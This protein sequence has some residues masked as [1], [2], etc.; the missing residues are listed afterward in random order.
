MSGQEKF[1]VVSAGKT[2]RAK[3]PAEV[4]QEAAKAFSIPVAQARRLMV[5][6]WVIKDQLSSKQVIE[7]RARLQKVGL[8]V[9]VFP[10][11]QYDNRALVAKLEFAQKRRARS[12][13]QETAAAVHGAADNMGRVEKERVAK[14]AKATK[15]AKAEKVA[16]DTAAKTARPEPTTPAPSGAAP[17]PN[18]NGRA[19]AQ[20]EALFAGES[21]SLPGAAANRVRLLLGAIAAAVVPGLFVLLA[22]ICVYSVI[23]TLWGLVQSVTAGDL[24]LFTIAGGLL[25]LSLIAFVAAI[26]L[27]PLVVA[28]RFDIGAERDHVPLPRRDAQGLYLLLEVLAER[29]GLPS[30]SAISVTAG[31]EI[32][33]GPVDFAA[34]RSRQI[35]LS[36]GLGAICSL[37]GSEVAALVARALGIY[38]DKLRGIT[39][40]LVLGTARRLQLWQWALENDRTPLAPQGECSVLARPFHRLLALCGHVLVPLLDRIGELHGRCSGPVARLL[41]QEGDASAAQVVGSEDFV[42]F[43]EKWHQLVHAELVVAEVNREAEVAGQRMADFPQ[44]IQWTLQNLDDETRSNIELAMAQTS[45][46]WDT[47]QAADN[48]RIA[49]VE[50][51]ALPRLVEREFSVQK[52]IDDLPA[53]RA[54]VSMRVAAESTRPVDNRQ[55]LRASEESE[56]SLAILGEY[57]NQVALREF[58]PEPPSGDEFAAMDLQASVDWLRGKL[59]D[60]RELDQRRNQLLTRG[61]AIRVGAGLV[62]LQGKIEPHEYFLSGAT[63]AAADESLKDNRARIADLQSQYRQIFG[64]FRL[65]IEL[66]VAAMSADARS[67]A[68]RQLA[69]LEGYGGLAEPREKLDQYAEVLGLLIDRLS[70]DASQWEL[71]QK[72]YDMAAAALEAVFARAERVGVPGLVEA[73]EA[74][75]GRLSAGRLPGERQGIV[76]ALQALEIRCKNVSAA[77]LDHYRIQLAELLRACQQ[78]ERSMNIRPLRLVGSLG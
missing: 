8:R 58:L 51:L 64:V 47:A 10:A 19:R 62:R 32:V 69:Q 5:K 26:L 52:L 29:T 74:R 33:A 2:L 77:L 35:P 44:A 76:D 23:G 43:A 24:G 22:G 61:A 16:T 21:A 55:L 12:G 17:S 54:E 34:I 70:L 25:S 75:A 68:Q 48:E 30:I 45:D 65:R 39:A 11:G 37:S 38:R 73:L 9:E 42:R 46:A 15:A 66:A 60:A 72:F 36:L 53:L 50:K 6:G 13:A 63:P 7:Y 57:F 67:A 1:Q 71:V 20:V 28:R 27:W 14:A 56:A 40:R 3:T 78:Q 31:A 41:E 59:L 49:R 18:T 4:V